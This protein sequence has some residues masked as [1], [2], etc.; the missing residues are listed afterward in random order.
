VIPNA[1]Y[2]VMGGIVGRKLKDV[3]IRIDGTLKFS[4]RADDWPR[5]GDGTDA[6]VLPCTRWDALDNVTFTSSGLG[7]LDGQGAAWWG[8]PGVG[9][10]EVGENRPRLFHADGGPRDVLVENL[11]CAASCIRDDFREILTGK[12]MKHRRRRTW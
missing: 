4:T 12:T 3:V 10:L 8:F 5:T 2:H 1:T 11:R 9:Y 7:T 6:R